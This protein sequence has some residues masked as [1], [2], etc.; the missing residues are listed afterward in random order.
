MGK[1]VVREGRHGGRDPVMVGDDV[2]D[3][4]VPSVGQEGAF[5]RDLASD[6]L[7]ATQI[8][9]PCAREISLA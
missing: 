7:R 8:A 2:I 4:R 1:L 6:N 9:P 3:S 5:M